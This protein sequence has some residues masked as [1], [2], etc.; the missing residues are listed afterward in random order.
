[1]TDEESKEKLNSIQGYIAAHGDKVCLDGFFTS[2][3][4]RL[5]ADCLEKGWI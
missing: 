5:I 1:M 3:E 2:E 4:L